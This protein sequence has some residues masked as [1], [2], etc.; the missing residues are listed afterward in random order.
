MN[1]WLKDFAK[2]ALNVLIS[3]VIS[4]G[5]IGAV[6]SY[7]ADRKLRS[8]ELKLEKYSALGQELAKLASNNAD[9]KK[10]DELLNGALIFGSEEVASSVLSLNKKL[11]DGTIAIKEGSPFISRNEL[12]PIFK[13][14]RTD[15]GESSSF[16]DNQEDIWFFQMGSPVCL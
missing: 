8:H 10:L 16:L 11:R 5:L 6:V 15:L 12:V 4:T 13:A 9:P 2:Q 3:T 1:K 7:Q 14:I